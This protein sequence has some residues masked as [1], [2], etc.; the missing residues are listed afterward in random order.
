FLEGIWRETATGGRGAALMADGLFMTLLGTLD[1]LAGDEE[2]PRSKGES[3][4]LD[5]ARL[6]R[7]TEYIE[8]NLDRTIVIRELA[9]IA[10][11]S[12]FHFSRC[13]RAATNT[14]PHRFVTARRIEA[15]KRMLADPA[16][17]LAQIAFACGF[18]NQSHFTKT[19]KEHVG[20]TPGAYRTQAS[21]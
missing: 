18:S 17:P 16:I 21:R 8:A 6:A 2:R 14:S 11:L 15:S 7:V 19:F 13:F 4:S 5:A 9:D 3:A 1:R 12:A 20:A 10:S